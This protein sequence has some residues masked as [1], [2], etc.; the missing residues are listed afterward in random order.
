M[1]ATAQ[2][3]QAPLRGNLDKKD[4]ERDA[5]DT[6][7]SPFYGI[8]KGAVLQESRI[9]NDR[10]IDPR[11]CQQVITKLLYLLTQGESFT[12]K[13]SSEVFFAVTKLFQN[14]DVNLRRMVYLI[15]KDIC[16]GS[17]EVIIVTSSLMKDMNSKTDLY[18][19]NAI[20]VLCKIIDSQLLAQ[21]ERYLKQAVVDKSAVVASAVLVSGLHLLEENPEIVKR[22]TNEVQEAVQ[23]KHSMVQFHAVALLHALRQNDRLAVSKLVTTLTRGSV[24]S[25]LAQCL[26]VRYVSEVIAESQGGSGNEDRPFY[27]FLDSCLRH[28]SEMVIFEAARAIANM[29]N[30]SNREL[31]PAITV[32]QLFL[33]SSKPVLRFAAVRTLNKVAMTHPMAVT[34]CNIDMESLI[35]DQNRSI[36]TLAITTLLKTG[37]EGSVERLLKQISN[38]MSEI[39]DEFKIVVV[40]AIRSLC[41]KFPQKYRALMN[42]LSSILRE[43]GG[44]EYKK[45]IVD[46]ILILIREIPDAK[47]SGLSHLCEFIEDCEF[48]YLSTQILHLLGHEGPATVEPSKYIRY[49][50]NRIILEN[51]T[52][53]AAAVASL[54]QFGAQVEALRPRVMT[55]IRRALHDNDDEVR[56]RATLYLAQ[57]EGRA[58]GPAKVKNHMR[59]PVKNIEATLKSYAAN[60]TGEPFDLASVPG[61][62]AQPVRPPVKG[63][64]SKAAKAEAAAAAKKEPLL[65]DYAVKLSAIPEIAACGKL[66][67][68]SEPQRLTEEETEYIVTCIKH[69]FEAHVVFQF[70]CTNTISEQ[71]LEDV[72]VTMDLADAEEF[73][74]EAVI[75]LSVMPYNGNGETYV[76]LSRPAGSMAVGSFVNILRFTVKEVDPTTGDAEEDGYEDEYQL[77]DIEV[78]SANYIK[79][80]SV[81]NFRKTWEEL[82]TSTEREDDYGLG[83]RDALQDAVESVIGILGMQPC[84]GTDA[85]PPNSRSHTVLLAGTV[86]GYQQV[87]VR[88]NF[89]I[90]SGGN[91][92]MKLCVR[93]EDEDISDA[94]HHIIQEA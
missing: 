91:V 56:D 27:D 5:E 64:G 2:D 41:L 60:P 22:W 16:P 33:S 50:Y 4:D 25:P 20:R 1:A 14:K 53:R 90:D 92:A 67:K 28:K 59:L 36:A 42:F 57:L 54:A 71:V 79:P 61:E 21:I 52:V 46:S 70:N 38:F 37:N 94:I 23:S 39:A 69:V 48:T 30:V 34:N 72:S 19:S 3:S 63:K 9:F 88:M 66:F 81:A 62:I 7:Y 15:I 47:E 26:L 35:S 86:V 6:E 68:S 13:E 18:R 40:E 77:E 75:P 85:V 80:T 31:T 43:E 8:E 55:L 49:I 87:L 51:A 84:E 10:D 29:N 74:E 45:A 24:R 89:G 58:G 65:E 73:A 82:D 78:T 11:R 17:D 93:S 32:L 76:I 83:H 44:F 12:K